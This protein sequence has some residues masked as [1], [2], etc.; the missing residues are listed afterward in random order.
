ML[1]QQY[2]D[3]RGFTVVLMGASSG[4]GRAAALAF[5]REGAQLVL[6]S[7][8]EATLQTVAT[9]C[10][11]LGAQ[12][13]VVP[14]DVTDAKA[15][16]ELARAAGSRF[17]GID[18]WVNNVG[19]GAVGRFVD[20]PIA[21]HRRVIE[22][23]LLGYMHGAHAVLPY[24]LKQRCGVLINTL[25]LGAWA[26]SPYATAYSASKFALRGFSEAL[27]AELSDQ[28]CVHVCNVFPA[29]MD[30]PGISHAA[31]YTGKQLRPVPPLYAPERVAAAM[32]SLAKRPRASVTVGS[33]A[34]AVRL[35]H[36]VSP[37]LFGWI[38]AKVVGAYL[39]RAPLASETNGNLFEP[40][41]GTDI[42]GGYR[43]PVRIGLGGAIG[44]GLAAALGAGWLMAQGQR[45]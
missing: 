32:V 20:T 42:T 11:A 3:I 36:V 4:I 33:A 1:T 25:S 34:H 18:I 41:V 15:V 37:G 31:N 21:A 28:P 5:A 40:S 30:S 17:G 27:R 16:Q 7:R 19:V 39:K 6:A 9:Q 29:F 24:F 43:S 35:G 12:T 8:N 44:L 23:N 38:S 14:T 10:E 13:L 45:R 22:S 2:P 26:P